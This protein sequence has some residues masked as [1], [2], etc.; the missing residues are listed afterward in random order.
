M[1]HP[2]LVAT[3]PFTILG[4]PSISGS[5]TFN[6]RADGSGVPEGGCWPEYYDWTFRVWP[7]SAGDGAATKVL[8]YNETKDPYIQDIMQTRTKWSYF[9][10]S[11]AQYASTFAG[12]LY[13]P[14]FYR[15]LNVLP[16]GNQTFHDKS[17]IRICIDDENAAVA[18]PYV[19]SELWYNKENEKVGIRYRWLRIATSCNAGTMTIESVEMEWLALRSDG[20]KPEDYVPGPYS[21][22]WC[23][24]T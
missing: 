11:G 5:I 21:T 7:T 13:P 6:T 12:Q 4:I 18:N 2:L 10:G 17:L 9:G 19:P 15:P 20:V 22:D 14:R 3:Y 8:L 24:C 23:T 1:A 16:I